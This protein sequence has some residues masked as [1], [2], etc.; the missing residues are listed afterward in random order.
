MNRQ[1]VCYSI[2]SNNSEGM[3][4][5]NPEAGIHEADIA[6]TI[7]YTGGNPACNQGGVMIVDDKSVYDSQV[8]HG[9]KEFADGISQTVNAQYGTGGNNQ[10]LVVA[11]RQG[12]GDY[13]ESGVASS[14]KQRDYKDATDLVCGI[15]GEQQVRR[16]TPLEC[17]RLQGFPDGWVDL[18]GASDSAKYKALGNSIARP[19][20]TWLAKR[21]VS[22]GDVKTIG[23]LFDGIGG[24]PL[25][26]ME[27]GAETAWT[28]EIEPFCRQVVKYHFGGEDEIEETEV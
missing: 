28:S 18:P 16:L 3:K 19:F 2:G 23:S 10:P 5:S 22:M 12:I 7:D 21:F 11:T 24:F 17:T 9:C 1:A 15:Q 4:S 26:F 14:C 27:A 20:W 6:R 25:C 13:I 8:Y